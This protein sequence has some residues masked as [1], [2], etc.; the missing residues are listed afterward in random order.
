MRLVLSQIGRRLTE[1]LD[2]TRRRQ[3]L[4]LMLHEFAAL[5][6]LDF[7]E[8]QLAFMAATASAAY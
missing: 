5:G 2:T 7:F 6:R 1:T 4:L 8:S 3:Q